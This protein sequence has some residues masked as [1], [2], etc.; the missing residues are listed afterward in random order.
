MSSASRKRRDQQT[1]PDDL[2]AALLESVS[3]APGVTVSGLRKHVPVSHRKFVTDAL[4]NTLAERGELFITRKGKRVFRTDPSLQIEAMVLEAIGVAPGVKIA[5]FKKRLPASHQDLFTETLISSLARQGE[6]FVLLKG[7]SKLAFPTDPFIEIDSKLPDEATQRPIGKDELKALVAEAAPGYEVVFDEWLKRALAERRLFEHASPK[8]RK[9]RIGR[10]PDLS[11][12]LKAVLKEL[13][14]ALK[15][16]DQQ[17]VP[18]ERVAATLVEALG[19]PMGAALKSARGSSSI[20]APNHE[21]TIDGRS[22]FL[23]ALES[24]ANDNPRDALHS[25]RALRSR[26]EL[27]KQE[28]DAIALELARDGVVTLHHHDHAAALAENDRLQLIQDN[29]GTYFNG[30]AF[31]RGHD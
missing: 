15:A 25:V 11:S 17:G 2:E 4:V 12:S 10:E 24:L 20:V 19:L 28:F 18:R 7:K 30:I 26:V 21:V 13:A 31:R 8:G 27:R 1:P 14:A 5:G 9:K 23:A 29:R 22:Q 6:L 16:L 3:A